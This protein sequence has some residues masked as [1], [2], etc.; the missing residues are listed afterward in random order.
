MHQH[1]RSSL[2]FMLS[3]L[4]KMLPLRKQ[5]K[6]HRLHA[7]VL[8]LFMIMMDFNSLEFYEVILSCLKYM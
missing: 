1:A 5:T 7:R 3:T 4:Y 6:N 8:L 2:H